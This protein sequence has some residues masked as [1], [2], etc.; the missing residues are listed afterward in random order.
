MASQE[1]LH[2]FYSFHFRFSST[3]Y[4]QKTSLIFWCLW[5]YLEFLENFLPLLY[6][7][8]GACQGSFYFP[9][10]AGA[11]ALTFTVWTQ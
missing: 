5:F 11:E 10:S 1:L 7:V 3:R 4:D 2:D 6:E 8:P 9:F